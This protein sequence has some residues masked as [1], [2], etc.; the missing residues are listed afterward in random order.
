M[1]TPVQSGVHTQIWCC[2]GMQKMLL[3]VRS[4]PREMGGGR[5]L[6][7]LATQADEGVVDLKVGPLY[8]PDHSS[9]L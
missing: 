5:M 2:A 4:G 7:S 8:Y 1:I 6:S 3:A 9:T